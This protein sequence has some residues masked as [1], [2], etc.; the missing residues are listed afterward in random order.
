MRPSRG[1]PPSASR[2]GRALDPLPGGP[3]G[4]RGRPARWADEASPSTPS[5]VEKEIF[6]FFFPLFFSVAR[7]A[8]LT[9][10]VLLFNHPEAIKKNKKPKPLT[11]P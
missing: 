10:N 1:A 8:S 3:H 5:F 9:W 6:N 7:Y 11:A 2:S 4:V